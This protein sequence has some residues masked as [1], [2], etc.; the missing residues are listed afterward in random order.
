[1]V[2]RKLISLLK[3]NQALKRL[4]HV[5]LYC[6]PNMESFYADLAFSTDID[7]IK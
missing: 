5:E 3:P 4:K 7:V 2:E 6:L 1:M